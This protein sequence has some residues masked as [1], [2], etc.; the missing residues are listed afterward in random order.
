MLI[1]EFRKHAAQQL[2]PLY[3]KTEAYKLIDILLEEFFSYSASMLYLNRDQALNNSEED[4]LLVALEKLKQGMPI[5]YVLGKAWF[6]DL[7]IRVNEATLIPRPETEELVNWVVEENLN[8][9]NLRILEIGTGSG[10]IALALKK[11]L[12]FSS[13][14]ATDISKQALFVAEKNATLNKLDISFIEND[15]LNATTSNLIAGSF[16]VIV[17]N[18]PYIRR[19]EAVSMHTNVL[20]FEPHLALFVEEENPLIFYDAIADYAIIYQQKGLIVYFEINEKMG[21]TLKS[22]L[23][24]KGFQSVQL[25]KDMFGK[26][27]MLRA[28]LG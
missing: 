20:D 9:D 3:E 21:D 25:K 23:I 2:Q 13:I 14:T 24:E 22:S 27:R 4:F 28:V 15:I 12:P 7:H 11:F 6:F 18:P 26:L 5:Q 16:D 19:S 8:R 1:S 10:C 17:S